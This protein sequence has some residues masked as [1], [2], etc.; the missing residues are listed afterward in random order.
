LTYVQVVNNNNLETNNVNIQG[1]SS[2]SAS[3][4]KNTVGGNVKS[5]GSVNYNNTSTSYV[6]SNN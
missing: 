4:S 6:I 5:G 1:S 3:S 2:G